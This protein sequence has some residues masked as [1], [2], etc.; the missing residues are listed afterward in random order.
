MQNLENSLIH[1]LEEDSYKV[2]VLKGQWGVGK[3]YFWRLFLE[4]YKDKLDFRAYSYVSLFGAENISEVKRS[5]FSNFD[6]LREEKATDRFTEW[7]KPISENLKKIDIPYYNPSQA[8]GDWIE[9]K[10]VD[11]FLICFDD[12]ERKEKTMSASSVLG[13]VSMLKEEKNCKIL[14]IY[15]ENELDDTTKSEINDYREK[16]VDLELTYNPTIRDNLAII[17]GPTYW[18]YLLQ[19][20]T[21]LNLNNIRVMQRVKW[22]EQYFLE[23]LGENYPNLIHNFLYN[24]AVLSVIHYTHSEQITIEQ[25]S[26][27]TPIEVHLLKENET[28]EEGKVLNLLGYYKADYDRIIIDYLN[29]G[30]VDFTRY[31]FLLKREDEN[32]RLNNIKRD[33]TQIWDKL[34]TN[35]QINQDEFI[36]ELYQFVKANFDDMEDNQIF[37]ALEFIKNV[38]PAIDI[39]DLSEKYLIKY[40]PAGENLFDMYVEDLKISHEVASKLRKSYVGNE[41]AQTLSE[42]FEKL[43][44]EERWFNYGLIKAFT[45]FSEEEIYQWLID[46]K[47]KDFLNS[48]QEFLYA[49]T[50]IPDGKL[51]YQKIRVAIKKIEQRSEFDKRRMRHIRVDI[52]DKYFG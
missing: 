20:F 32:F 40:L 10:F 11:N 9:N 39:D 41:Q 51:I 50:N 46:E 22:A 31:K 49:L 29:N 34:K 8:I 43:S 35:F 37:Q 7:L 23:N 24:S 25:I 12:L 19:I 36:E 2:A 16:V 13:L 21:S 27:L 52:A 28:S 45:E 1:F 18:A 33:Y 38:D 47:R 30:Y 5:I 48:L 14:L 4:T 3:T 26:E 6:I 15:N 17:W 42:I 44:W